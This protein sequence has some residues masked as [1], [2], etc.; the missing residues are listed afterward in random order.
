MTKI[1]HDLT[2]EWYFSSSGPGMSYS[3]GSFIIP[4]YYRENQLVRHLD[5]FGKGFDPSG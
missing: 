3:K 5:P 2:L 4:Y 1:Q